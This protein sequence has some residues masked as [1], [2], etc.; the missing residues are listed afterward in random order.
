V[1]ITAGTLIR[2]AYLL[3][4]VLELSEEP[5]G[6]YA[7][8]GLIS[9]ND[10]I[11]QWGNIGIYI[12]YD[13]VYKITLQPGVAT[14]TT[15][16]V[17]VD[18]NEGNITTPNSSDTNANLLTPLKLATLKERNLFN[19]NFQGRPNLIYLERQQ[20]ILDN[21]QN[22]QGSQFTLYPTPDSSYDL[23]LNLKWEL[24]FVNLF[25][26]LVQFPNYYLKPL[27]YQL[28]K[29]F[30]DLYKTV[31]PPQ[32]F[33]EYNRLMQELKATNPSDM[34]IQNSNPFLER[35]PFRPRSYYVL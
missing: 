3:A 7:T 26:Q 2:D 9:L 16:Q 21:D 27:K 20:V 11:T 19:D 4:S 34:S 18:I 14:Y 22:S 12:P 28:A 6:F 1:T 10:V 33:E 15:R 29:D 30:S 24:R 23:T 8:Q 31:L 25:E 17:I 5:Q 35:R 32:F 13:S